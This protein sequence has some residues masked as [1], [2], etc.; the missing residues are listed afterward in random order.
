MKTLRSLGFICSLFLVLLSAISTGQTTT[1]VRIVFYRAD[2]V[3]P[4]F[5]T[6]ATIKVDGKSVHKIGNM[7]TWSTAI[8][9]G[10][11]SIQGDESKYAVKY[12]F[13]PGKTYYFAVR[14]GSMGVIHPAK[15]RIVPVADN[16]EA[17]GFKEEN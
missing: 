13:E 16:S 4:K 12:T 3:Y 11:H 17:T 10:E 7:A 8:A 15:F 14:L 2:G 6:R 5:F 9:P 1:P